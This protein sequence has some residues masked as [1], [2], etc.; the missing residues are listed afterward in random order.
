METWLGNRRFR[1]HEA[2]IACGINSW[3]DGQLPPFDATPTVQSALDP[4]RA[5]HS[6]MLLARLCSHLRL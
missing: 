3:S 5:L 1:Q 6:C 4:T 2:H